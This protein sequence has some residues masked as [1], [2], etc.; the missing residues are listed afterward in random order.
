MS[1]NPECLGTCTLASAPQLAQVHPAKLYH[2]SKEA[3]YSL[4]LPLLS[5]QGLE[6]SRWQLTDEP[7]ELT[8]QADTK[9]H[10]IP[11]CPSSLLLALPV[12]SSGSVHACR[13]W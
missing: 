9:V 2:R 10:D 5:E 6:V 11:E 3:L 1:G 4:A 13:C 8:N 12:G 7:A